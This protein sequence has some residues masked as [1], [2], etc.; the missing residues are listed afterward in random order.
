M[1]E[2]GHIRDVI[3]ELSELTNKAVQIKGKGLQ[4]WTRMTNHP[5]HRLR[6]YNIRNILEA[7]FIDH[8]TF[9]FKEVTHEHI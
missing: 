5:A 7:Q 9:K 4:Q 6:L 8:N 3:K 2:E 1:M